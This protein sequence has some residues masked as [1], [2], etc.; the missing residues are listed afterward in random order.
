MGGALFGG[1]LSEALVFFSPTPIIK[2]AFLNSYHIGITP[3]VTLDLALITLTL[4]FTVKINLLILLGI[5]L[6]V[7]T[8][9][10]L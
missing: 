6:G 4:G 2:D 8:Y 5:L 10:Q 1:L 9:R 3:P 7:Y